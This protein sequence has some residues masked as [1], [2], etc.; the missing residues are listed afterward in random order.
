MCQAGEG[1]VS[2]LTSDIERLERDTGAET[3]WR[4]RTRQRKAERE[5]RFSLN[6]SNPITAREGKRP[7]LWVEFGKQFITQGRR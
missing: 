3:L 2:E 6:L 5:S 7:A 1:T 4:R